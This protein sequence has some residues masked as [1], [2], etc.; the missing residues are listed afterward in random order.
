[1]SVIPVP[2][3]KK[4]RRKRGF[5]QAEIFAKGIAEMLDQTDVYKDCGKN[6]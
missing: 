3:H 2:I 5:N 6:P 1:M 4:K